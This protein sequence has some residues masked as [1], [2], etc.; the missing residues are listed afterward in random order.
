MTS[1]KANEGSAAL[2]AHALGEDAWLQAMKRAKELDNTIK[3][4]GA[5]EPESGEE[6]EDPDEKEDQ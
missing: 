3:D 5:Y 2:N 1:G 6:A 4:V